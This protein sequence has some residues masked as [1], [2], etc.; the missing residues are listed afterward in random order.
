MQKP[1]DNDSLDGDR[2]D[3]FDVTPRP[4]K[5]T[6]RRL[7]V[8]IVVTA[9]LFG[10]TFF[11]M[12][13]YQFSPNVVKDPAA[14]RNIASDPIGVSIPAPWEPRLALVTENWLLSMR[15]I[16]LSHP[17]GGIGVI[18]QVDPHFGSPNE[19]DAQVQQAR[20][21]FE[22]HFRQLDSPIVTT[23]VAIV[24]GQNVAIVESRG[25]DLSSNGRYVQLSMEFP[26]L[27]GFC[28]LTLET[29]EAAWTPNTVDQIL[30]GWAV[31]DPVSFATEDAST[32]PAPT[33]ATP[34]AED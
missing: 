29:D 19:M 11:G 8:A 10:F 13:A 33:E 2:Y 32:A 9:L 18:Q 12:L 15:V 16:E 5:W 23:T 22:G 24:R 30:A 31:T 4:R 34:A 6:T 14:I 25:R 27:K 21:S 3:P 17:R 7:L 26:A 1:V 28:S 20:R